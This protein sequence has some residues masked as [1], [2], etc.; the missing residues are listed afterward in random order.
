MNTKKTK[1]LQ[2]MKR[3]DKKT[4]SMNMSQYKYAESGISQISTLVSNLMVF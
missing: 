2:D 3:I 4:E 1:I